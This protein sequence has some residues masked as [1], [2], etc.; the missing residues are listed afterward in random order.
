MTDIFA[1]RRPGCGNSGKRKFNDGT[2]QLTFMVDSDL[3]KESEK[4]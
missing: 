3:V 4:Q 1:N 2:V